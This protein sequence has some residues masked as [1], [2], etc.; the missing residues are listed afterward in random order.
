MKTKDFYRVSV[1]GPTGSGKSQF[2]NFIQRDITNSINKVSD[3]LNSCTKEPVSNF[4]TRDNTKYEFIDSAGNSDS[5]NDDIKNLELFIDYIKKKESIDYISLLLKFGERLT[6]ETK[7]YLEKL[8]KIFTPAEF[9]THLCVFFTKFPSNPSKKENRLKEKSIDE[10]NNILKEIF[11]IEKDMPLPDVKVYFIDTEVDEDDKTYDEKSQVNIDIM[12]K[13]MKIDV[14]K[15]GS[16]NTKTFDAIGEDCKLRKENEKKLIEELKKQLEE[17]KLK[18]EKEEKEKMKLQEDIKKLKDDEERRKKKEEYNKIVERQNRERNQNLIRE[19]LERERRCKEM[20]KEIEELAKQKGI[21]IEKLDRTI[22]DNLIRAG[23]M[24]G[25]GGTTAL[26]FYGL[27]FLSNAL[28]GGLTDFQ[29]FALA[30]PMIGGAGVFAL[31]AVPLLI[32]G[33]FAIKKKF[34]V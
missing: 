17:A 11:K 21:Q 24:A 4:F 8:G 13:Q 23:V 16:I 19:V 26:S 22:K 5:D 25:G 31:S 32:A 33:G 30:A 15:F 34:S 28:L 29:F 1:I 14:M 7:K 3:S 20:E 6:N 9:Y 10:I 12:M 2:C 18:N 27:G